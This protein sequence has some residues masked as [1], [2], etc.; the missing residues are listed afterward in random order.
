MTFLLVVTVTSMLLAAIMSAIA[1]RLARDE[2]RRSDARVAALAAEIHE[3]DGDVGRVSSDADVGRV[4][5]DPPQSRVRKDPA[6]NSQD[7]V[8]NSQTEPTYSSL[9]AARQPRSGAR[10]LAALV[11]GVFAVGALA[12][13]AVVL[14]RVLTRAPRVVPPA[15][16]MPSPM[17]LELVALGHER[18][19]DQ[20]TV[21]GVVRNPS[22]GTAIDRLTAVV[23]VVAPG[24]EYLA[25]GRSAVEAQ[26]LQPGREATFAVT[27]PGTSDVGRYRVSFR[28]GDRLVP[29]LD[30][31]HEG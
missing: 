12:A 15:A 17:P 22:T 11:V 21:R 10:P 5:S 6:Y 16:A 4:L 3:I 18:V 13:M 8:Y 26:A 19:G 23:S 24:G 14:P 31:R 27:V 1:W 28:T 7:L 2:G 25:T 30:R 9:F 29:H 20:L